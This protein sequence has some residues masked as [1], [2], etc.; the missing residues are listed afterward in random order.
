MKFITSVSLCCLV[1]LGQACAKETGPVGSASARPNVLLICIDDLRPELKSFGASYIQSP[2]IDRLA[3]T[4]RPFLRHYVT[5][6]SCGPSRYTMLTG[7]YHPQGKGNAHLFERAKRMAKD[8]DSV[9]PSMPEWFRSNGYTTVSVGKVSHHP[10]GLG[11]RNWDDSKLLEMPNAWDRHIMPVAEWEHPRGAMHGYANGKQRIKKSGEAFLFEAVDGPDT[12]YPDGLIAEEGLRQLETLAA[13]DTPFFLA[14]GLIK[15]HL[16]F[17]APQK[18]LDRY[19]GVELPP[20]A[21]PEKPE[22]QTTWHRSG[23]CMGY[24]KDVKHAVPV[25]VS[26]ADHFQR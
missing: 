14:I 11:G 5:A 25:G 16:P 26:P 22:G 6:P 23:E 21:H 10:G 24:V 7:L 8:P 4:G 1:I 20:I 15:P 13:A 19:E 3:A 17:G 12:I 9:A 18:Y 2:N